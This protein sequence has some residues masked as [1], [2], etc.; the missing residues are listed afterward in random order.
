[1][2]LALRLSD[3]L[4]HA[5]AAAPHRKDAAL[6]LTSRHGVLTMLPRLLEKREIVLGFVRREDARTATL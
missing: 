1:M 3:G 4:G 5:R 2:P 6:L